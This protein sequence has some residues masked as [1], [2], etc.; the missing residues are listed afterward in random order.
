MR[1]RLSGRQSQRKP[2]SRIRKSSR[3][4]PLPEAR[5]RH[6]ASANP[7][8]NAASLA[9]AAGAA[10]RRTAWSRRQDDRSRGHPIGLATRARVPSVLQRPSHPRKSKSI[11]TPAVSLAWMP[12]RVIINRSC[13]MSA[14]PCSKVIK[15]YSSI[16]ASLCCPNRAS[17]RTPVSQASPDCSLSLAR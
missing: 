13:S 10:R 5:Q 15:T 11:R 16:V 3:M 4:I 8:S 17:S 2:H 14:T 7:A 6:P 1:L 12:R 9:A